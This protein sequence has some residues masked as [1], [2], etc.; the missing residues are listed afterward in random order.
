MSSFMRKTKKIWKSVA[1]D[2]DVLD[3]LCQLGEGELTS[4]ILNGA[5]MFVCKMYGRKTIQSVNELR[6]KLFW[7]RTRKNGKVPDLSLLPPCA[8]SLSKH[9][10]RAH[11]VAK[12]WRQANIPL[13]SVGKFSDNGWLA[14][15]SIDWIIQ[16]YPS[17]VASILLDNERSRLEGNDDQDND[18][19]ENDDD[20]DDD[21]IDGEIDDDVM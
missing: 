7:S 1:E 15:G 17:N 13:Q 21:E 2:D 19:D 10:A 20:D 11:H 16:A 18:V 14:D 12:I 3:F 4:D 9:T 8:S 5:E 6:A